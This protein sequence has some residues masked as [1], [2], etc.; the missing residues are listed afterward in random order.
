MKTLILSTL[1]I[2]MTTMGLAHAA[3]AQ[4]V[5]KVEFHYKDNCE[6][7]IKRFNDAL[8][9]PSS[10]L[11]DGY[12]KGK[13]VPNKRIYDGRIYGY[14]LDGKLLYTRIKNEHSYSTK[15]V[16]ITFKDL[17]G[18]KGLAKCKILEKQ[19]IQL[20]NKPFTIWYGASKSCKLK[21]PVKGSPL[22]TNLHFQF[23]HGI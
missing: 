7:F 21:Y 13:C 11:V 5:G 20:T 9:G 16:D 22:D 17:S 23:F 8:Q 6:D 4:K 18:K 1:V 3:N 2:M 19:L 12:L 10:N 14:H 15:V